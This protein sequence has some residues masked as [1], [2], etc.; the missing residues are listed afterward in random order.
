MRFKFRLAG[1]RS[2]ESHEPL[3][4]SNGAIAPKTVI[5]NQFN[6]HRAYHRSDY[7]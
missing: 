2:K 1:N 4:S 6:G 5:G 7:Y 3:H